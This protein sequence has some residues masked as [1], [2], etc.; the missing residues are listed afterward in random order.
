MQV[1]DN[2]RIR[3]NNVTAHSTEQ[4]QVEDRYKC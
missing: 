2:L 1:R 4:H 3:I